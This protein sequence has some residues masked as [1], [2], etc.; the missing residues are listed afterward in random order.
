[1]APTTLGPL[2]MKSTF[3]PMQRHIGHRRGHQ[4]KLYVQIFLSEVAFLLSD[5]HWQH[6][7]AK[8][9]N[10]HLHLSRFCGGR[11]TNQ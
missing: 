10:R 8:S 9:R 7:L 6:G 11:K 3:P 1:M 2:E 4:N 5:D